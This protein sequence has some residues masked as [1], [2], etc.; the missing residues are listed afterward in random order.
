AG[1]PTE[2][3]IESFPRDLLRMVGYYG[4]AAGAAAAFR[5]LAVGLDVA[6]VRVV[7]ARP[8]LASVLN[9]IRACRPS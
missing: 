2:E 5:R 7:P 3:V 4:P 1:A 8:G 6:L 9:V